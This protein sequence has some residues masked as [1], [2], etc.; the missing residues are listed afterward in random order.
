VV[1]GSELTSILLIRLRSIGDVILTTP[2]VRALRARFPDARLSYLV[3]PSA[4]P[5]IE[6]NPHLDELIVVAKRSGLVRI[7]DDIAVARRL[8]RSRFDVAID[9]HG[10]PR[11]AWFAWSTGAP[12]RIGYSIPGRRWMYTHVIE[13]ARDLTPRHAVANQ[14]D[15]LKPLGIDGCDPARDPVEV[16]DDAAARRRVQDRLGQLGIGMHDRVAVMHVSANNPFRRWPAASF[17]ETAATLAARHPDLHVIV[18]S[19][20]SEEAAARAIVQQAR[21]VVSTHRGACAGH[22]ERIVDGHFDLAELRELV[23]RSAVYIGGDSGPLNLAATTHAPIIE[24]LG[25]TLAERAQPWRDPRW[26][27]EVVDAG[28]LPCRPCHQRHCEP[29]DFRCLTGVSA[30]RVVAAAERALERSGELTEAR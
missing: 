12:T 14:A 3:E 21:A 10:G 24:V 20:P 19:G 18:V 9:L 30:D 1:G 16:S 25:P 15:L 13:R 26:F 4:A 23:A 11:A 27:T 8:R 29:G 6:R 22:A 5:V 17:A 28:P 2:I 7:S